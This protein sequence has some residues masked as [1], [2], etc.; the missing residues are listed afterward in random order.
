MVMVQGA[1]IGTMD[2]K[3]AKR[4]SKG[5]F[6]ALGSRNFRLFYAGQGISLVGNFLQQVALGWFVYRT[7]GSKMLLG[8]IAFA[9]QIPSLV[10]AP[11]A[12]ALADRWDRKKAL[13][14]IHSLSGVQAAVLAALVAS[15]WAPIWALVAL[16][17][18][19]GIL[20][21]FDVPFR[22][23]F[24]SQMV[25]DRA[26]LPNALA[27]NSALFNAARLVGPS[28][29][30]VLVAVVGEDAC[31]ALN[32][33]SYLA[34]VAALLAIRPH[35]VERAAPRRL[36]HEI[37]EGV[38]YVRRHRPIRDLL[39]LVSAV[40]LLGL[41]YT[42][43]LPVVARDLLAGDA[44]TL[45][46]L[47]GAGGAGALAAALALAARSSVKGLLR[48]IAAA[49]LLA[50]AGVLGL[51]ASRHLGACM[52]SIAVSGFGFVTCAG[53]SNAVIQTLVDNRFRG[54]V[55]SLYTLAFLGTSTFGSL[56]AGWLAD[57]CGVS[58]SMAV[59]GALFLVCAVVF[60]LRLGGLR[61][62]VRARYAGM[63]GIP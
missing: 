55:M 30:G 34:V 49:A 21:A 4:R 42:V 15:G 23:A 48:R 61:R 11:F 62:D 35:P 59:L 58:V 19:L 28:L 13:V 37:L 50:G 5:V 53:G 3:P 10:C 2:G 46:L 44:R 41:A 29:G 40:G 26:L 39:F 22:Q 52:V 51:S 17:V 45:G 18:A 47:M 6:R 24:V 54:R 43:L 9:G 12:G 16:S 31:F 57:R 36:D 38:R 56:V 32:A 25:D 7:T 33:A 8:T 14:A 27:L 1:T 60:A 63:E 20:N